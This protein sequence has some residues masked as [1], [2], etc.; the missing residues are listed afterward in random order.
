VRAAPAVRV[1]V[2]PGVVSRGVPAVLVL[3]ASAALSAWALGWSGVSPGWAWLPTLVA[4][5]LVWR[6]GAGQAHVLAWDGVQ[7]HCDGVPGLVTLKLDL[8]HLVLLRWTAEAE[9]AQARWL[10]PTAAQCGA[11]WHALRVALLSGSGPARLDPP[12]TP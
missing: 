11:D 8:Q 5:V 4:A 10:V 2:K 7:W 9:P 1:N 12:I 3:L 6:L